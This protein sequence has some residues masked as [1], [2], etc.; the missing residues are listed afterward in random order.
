MRS[1]F[2]DKKLQEDFDSNGYVVLNLFEPSEIAELKRIISKLEV[3]K[4]ES[5]F[6]IETSYKLS[7]FSDSPAY[8]KR[9]SNLSVPIASLL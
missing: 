3:E 2:K 4:A 8:R 9:C 5:G 6:N 1:T 7:F